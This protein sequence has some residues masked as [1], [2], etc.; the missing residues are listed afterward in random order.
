MAWPTLAAGHAVEGVRV[1]PSAVAPAT[2][3][4]SPIVARLLVVPDPARARAWHDLLACEPHEAG[5]P[6]DQRT[7]DRLRDAF[8]DMG[9]E[10]VVEEFEAPLPLPLEGRIELLRDGAPPEVLPVREEASPT[11]A[12]AAHPRL[13]DGWNAFSADGDVTAPVVY[14]NLGRDED[15]VLLRERS[16]DCAGRVV[17]IRYGGG[18]RGHAVRRAAEAG[19]AAVVLYSDPS[20][21]GD[22]APGTWP[23][24]PLAADDHIERGSV[25]AAAQPGDPTTV[26][27]PS[28]A[29]SAREPGD[30]GGAPRIPVQ[31]V[32]A[33]AARRIMMTMGG[34]DAPAEWSPAN[35]LGCAYRL[36]GAEGSRVRV[37]VR[38]DRA[39]RRTG[40]VIA[41]W[42]GGSEPGQMV[43]AGCHHDAWGFGASDP[44]A[45]MVVMLEAARSF[46]EAA[47]AGFVPARSVVFAAWGAEE[48]GIFGSTEWVEGHLPR[49]SREAI[50]YVN[51]DMA[52][53]GPRVSVSASPSLHDIFLSAAVRVPQVGRADG[54][55]VYEAMC[56]AAP[57]Q[58]SP[59]IGALG[60][61][62][63]HVAFAC[64]AG[65]PS[66]AIG[67]G[68]S[69][70]RSYHSNHDTRA[71]YRLAVG[72]DYGAAVMLAR[73]TAVFMGAIADAPVVPLS[74]ARH[75]ASAAEDFRAL[76]T[77]YPE[78]EA[79]LAPLVT[80]A[81]TAAEQGERLD[82]SLTSLE[83]GLGLARRAELDAALMS[84]DRAWLDAGGLDGRPWF[85]HLGTGVDART[86]YAALRMPLLA[87]ALDARDPDRIRRAVERCQRALDRLEQGMS[88]AQE[89]VGTGI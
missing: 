21:N 76:I 32:G 14:A 42:R 78:S 41:R 85:R 13:R 62:S 12:D 19:A 54:A 40:N 2:D 10:V 82:A 60:G 84:L 48:H 59:S 38:Q 65:V 86:G 46:A 72:N 55:S 22:P 24:G 79:V 35:G 77:R 30:V 1:P 34:P 27:W 44:L 8:V 67:A 53:M 15:F 28:V 70:G 20:Q 89:L 57:G 17:M 50:A 74:A 3:G 87:E 4:V 45:G 69:R 6:G 75:G 11:D 7:I 25:L 88:L 23:Q 5:T 29:G 56:E 16:I 83:G 31:P 33:G 43:I 64:H 36:G 47:R 39:F 9:Y 49:L 63:D 81:E 58:P 37:V 66:I 61:G 51:L 71:W 52:A 80:R 18:F 26:G 73:L 68:G